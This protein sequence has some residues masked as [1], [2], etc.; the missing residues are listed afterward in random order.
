VQKQTGDE[1]IGIGVT[2]VLEYKLLVAPLAI[3]IPNP[4]PI[5]AWKRQSTT[6]QL[7]ILMNQP[8]MITVIKCSVTL[9]KSK[10]QSPI[11]KIIGTCLIL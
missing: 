3:T 9:I 4:N 6:L 5:W 7:V 11:A 1:Q 10:T 2:K 8:S